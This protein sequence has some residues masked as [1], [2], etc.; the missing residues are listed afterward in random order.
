MNEEVDSFLSE[1][2][3]KGGSG[4]RG[5]SAHLSPSFLAAKGLALHMK[6]T[7]EALNIVQNVLHGMG[8]FTSIS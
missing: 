1:K 7:K 8:R 3:S 4:N 5:V 2:V 6:H